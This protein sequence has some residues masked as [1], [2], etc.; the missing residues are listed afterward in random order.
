MAALVDLSGKRG[1]VVGIANESSIAAGCASA[2]REAGAEL[3]IT[4]LNEK[5]ERAPGAGP[6][7]ADMRT[8]QR[9][10]SEALEADRSR[11]TAD[12]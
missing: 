6:F 4:Y 3:A 8:G 7:T 1:L 12:P 9:G 11:S 10:S 5:A 2:F